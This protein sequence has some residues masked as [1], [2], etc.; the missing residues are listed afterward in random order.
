MTQLD[1]N[2]YVIRYETFI[3][4]V[5]KEDL[6]QVDLRLQEVNGEITDLIQQKHSLKVIMDKSIHPN[7]FKTQVNL[8][9]N[10]FMEAAVSDTSKLLM[11]I[12]LNHYLEF[13]IEEANRYLDVRI[14]AFEKKAEELKNQSA[15][16]KAH[17]KLMLF[18]IGKIQNKQGYGIS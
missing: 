17:I 14:K 3:N 4:D 15:E 11:N 9:C 1:T 16:T 7:G 2:D 6:R 5:L 10:F 12:G 18:H 13:N 8:G